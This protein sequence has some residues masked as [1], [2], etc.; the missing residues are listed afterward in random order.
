MTRW[1]SLDLCSS[2]ERREAGKLSVETR[3]GC[4]VQCLSFLHTRSYIYSMHCMLRIWH[5]PPSTDTNTHTDIH[6]LTSLNQPC[7][8]SACFHIPPLAQISLLPVSY[9]PQNLGAPFFMSGKR[10]HWT[11]CPLAYAVFPRVLFCTILSLR[12]T[13]KHTWLTLLGGKQNSTL[14]EQSRMVQSISVQAF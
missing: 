5:V 3:G 1:F 7:Q 4:R 9:G 8:R 2:G 13:P 11:P 14:R 10:L 12:C 6:F